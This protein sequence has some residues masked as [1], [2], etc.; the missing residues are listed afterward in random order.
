MGYSCVI[1]DFDD[2]LVDFKA[3]EDECLKKLYE[4]YAIETTQENLDIYKN[5]N[6][7]LWAEFDAGKIKKS[8]IERNRFRDVVSTFNIPNI[9]SEQLNKEYLN[10]LKNS[11]ILYDGVQEFLIDIEE[12]A[13]LCIITNGIDY[14]QKS[15]IKVSGL[16]DFFDGFY[17]SEKMGTS[18]P[19]KRAFHN[20]LKN[21]GIE[22]FKN[23]LVVGDN[24]NTDIKGAI[25]AGLDSCW[26]NMQNIE[27]TTKI[28]PKFIARDFTE[29][30]NII[31]GEE[32]KK[33]EFI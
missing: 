22:N 13:T 29:L 6:R 31:L 7:H 25:N 33:V 8:V 18:K 21:L 17:T 23:V 26:F 20:P 2:T 9:T 27:N 16:A 28:T 5:T 19:D 3:S 14:V 10:F 11:A 12:H 15:R 30:K 4:K 1:L 32:V 24:L